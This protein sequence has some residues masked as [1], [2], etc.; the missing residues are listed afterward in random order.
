[1]DGAIFIF[2][3]VAAPAPQAEKATVPFL[4]TSVFVMVAEVEN[5]TV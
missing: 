2:V 3:M 4:H 5:A 1:M